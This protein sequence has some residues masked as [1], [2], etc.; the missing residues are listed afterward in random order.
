MWGFFLRVN[1]IQQSDISYIYNAEDSEIGNSIISDQSPGGVGV[2][3]GPVF[4]GGWAV[5]VD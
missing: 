1:S 5:Y 4:P 3:P 2:Q